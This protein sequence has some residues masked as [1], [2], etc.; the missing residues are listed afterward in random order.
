M[1]K[2]L[3]GLAAAALLAQ[4]SEDPA[5]VKRRLEVLKARLAQ[6]D[7]Q[8][9]DLGRRRKGVLVDL[10]GIQLQRDRVRAQ[11][12]S[13]RLQ[14]DATQAQADDLAKQQAAIQGELDKLRADLGK[15]VRWMQAEG[16]WGE[17]GFL[18]SFDDFNQ[19][20]ERG[21]MLAWWRLQEQRRLDRI[22]SLKTQ[23]GQKAEA[24]RQVLAQL[25]VQQQQLAQSQAALQVQEDRLQAALDHLAEDEQSQKEAQSELQEEAVQLERLLNGLLGKKRPDAF[26]PSL[27]FE[28]LKGELPVPVDG[29]LA[30]GFGEH[31]HP[32]FHTKTVQTGLLVSAD[33]GA[34]V[35]AVADGKVVFAEAYQSYGPM[36]ILDHGDGWFSLYTHL[37]G[38][39]VAKG[40]VLRAGELVGEVGDTVDGPR[41]GFE[42]RHLAKPEDPQKWLKKKYR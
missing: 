39:Q 17:L 4:Q 12:E 36:V 14:R 7:Q 5:A 38:L 23:L 25:E 42:I 34:A 27:H 35:R 2:L 29:A 11:T 24:M 15:Q 31:V 28:A 9:Q 10:Q 41:L 19:Y 40:Q 32:K 8:L 6:M 13:A 21:R 33:L 37:Q 16:P 26:V 3:L 20:L 18:S 1:R 30:E 22:Q